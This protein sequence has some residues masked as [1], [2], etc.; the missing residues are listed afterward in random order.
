LLGIVKNIEF[1]LRHI[2]INLDISIIAVWH[3]QSTCPY[4]QSYTM[5]GCIR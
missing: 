2:T 5:M 1:I 4:E 3:H